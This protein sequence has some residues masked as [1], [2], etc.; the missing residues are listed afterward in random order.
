MTAQLAPTPVFRSV[1]AFGFPLYLGQLATFIAGTNTPQATYK[2]STQVATNTNPIILNPRGECNLW[3]D[4]TKAYK[5]TLS[6]A[7]GN[8]IW[9]VDNITIGN[10]NPSYS[11]IPT[12]DNLYNLGSPTFSWANIYAKGDLFLGPTLIPLFDPTTG[13]IGYFPRTAAEIALS[14]TPVN[15]SYPPMYV[16]RYGTNTIPGTTS[17]VIAF[18]AALKVAKYASLTA[19][20]SGVVRYGA[21]GTYFLDS[22]LDCTTSPGGIPSQN[23][24]TIRNEG[25]PLCNTTNPPNTASILAKHQGHVF[26]CTG[27]YGI[28]F[29]NVTISTDVTT[30]PKTGWLLARGTDGNSQIIHLKDCRFIGKASVAVLYNYGSENFL[31][32]ACVFIQAATDAGSKV[33]AVTSSNILAQSSTFQTIATGIKPTTV[34]TFR[35]GEYQHNGGSATSDVFYFENSSKVTIDGPFMDSVP[36]STSIRSLIYVD[37]TNGPTNTVSLRGIT[38]ESAATHLP[39]YGLYLGDTAAAVSYW[40]IDGCDLSCNTSR[41]FANTAVICD[42]FHVRAV[43]SDNGAGNYN[44]VG[45]LQNSCIEEF[46][47]NILIGT[48]KNNQLATSGNNLTVTTR[49]ADFWNDVTTNTW[50]QN[51]SALTITGALTVSSKKLANVGPLVFF[52]IQLSAATSIVCAAGTNLG[53]LPRGATAN[54]SMV[55]VQNGATNVEIGQGSVNGTNVVL[56]AINVGANVPVIISGWA[57]IA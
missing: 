57:Y 39:T 41:I 55:N 36:A 20:F 56:P 52:N 7:A 11:I 26:D 2:D 21:T 37:T 53:G 27:T 31:A 12:T 49:N 18:N 34:Q 38:S 44:F 19:A 22:P 4:P 25:N 23:G 35:D 40:V 29:E 16:D 14:V 47:T 1:D 15:F 9:T 28:N 8:L 42:D 13:V 3:L 48:S 50:T 10:A 32:Q 5:F 30:Y 54:S 6:D 24:F 43:S 33:V 51:T 17:M 45:T 46:A